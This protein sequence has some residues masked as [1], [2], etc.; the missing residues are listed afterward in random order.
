MSLELALPDWPV[1][2]TDEIHRV[3]QR[4]AAVGHLTALRWHSARPFSAAACV[5]TASGPVIVKRHHR[6]VRSVAALREEHS[7][8]A[9]L[10]WA[11]A[12]VVEVLHD[13]QG[14]TA[15]AHADWVYEVQRVGAG[16]DLYRD[17]LSWTP[18]T[19]VA[20]AR[21]AGAA[22]AQ[23][24]RAAQ[25]FDA[26]ARSTSMLVANLRLFAQADPVQALHDA[27]PTRPHLATA[28]QDRPGNTIW[29]PTCCPGM[30]RHGRCCPRRA[31]Y[32]RCGPMATG[33]RPTCCGTP[34]TERPASAPSSISD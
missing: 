4:F 15:L 32:R 31:R 5:D 33:M 28:L 23:L 2:T 21:A 29:P 9:H 11:G 16:R 3:L 20:H 6:S 17:A 22:L 25:G 26:P 1:L 30:R 27:L 13:A 18:F 10:R 34:T 14:R 19:D 7:F 24:H 12:P 8:M